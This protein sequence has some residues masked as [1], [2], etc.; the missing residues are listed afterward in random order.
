MQNVS[1]QFAAKF[2]SFKNKEGKLQ[3]PSIPL[4]IINILGKSLTGAMID[5]GYIR[6]EEPFDQMFQVDTTNRSAVLDLIKA[7]KEE[8]AITLVNSLIFQIRTF[9]D[10]MAIDIIWFKGFEFST[11]TAL[12]RHKGYKPADEDFKWSDGVIY[13]LYQDAD[14]SLKFPFSK[15]QGEALK[16]LTR[17]FMPIAKAIYKEQYL[18]ENPQRPIY[19]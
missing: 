1:N 16:S 9:K 15:E 10:G 5:C 4:S 14:S 12:S 6:I 17:K 11:F 2:D 19:D 3:I 8:K 7:P 13:N 18:K